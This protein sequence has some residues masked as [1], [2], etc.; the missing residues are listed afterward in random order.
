[1]LENATSTLTQNWDGRSG[2]ASNGQGKKFVGQLEQVANVISARHAFEAE[3]DIFFVE[4]NGFDTH[5]DEFDTVNTKFN[6]INVGLSLFVDEMKA[7]GVWDQVVVQSLSEFGRTVTTNGRGTDHA[8]GGNY[9]LVGGGVK[10]GTIHGEYPELRIDGPNSVS[11]NGHMMP[12]LPWEAIWKPLAQWLGVE[13]Q[14]LHD[15]MPNLHQF[16][17]EHLLETSDVFENP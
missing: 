1:M 2:A 9:F 10:G 13:D 4:M 16:S 12:S 3:R 15:V 17:D 14:K 11:A 5:N 7:Q 6:D 8:W